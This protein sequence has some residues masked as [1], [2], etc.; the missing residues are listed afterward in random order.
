MRKT[1]VIGITLLLLLAVSAGCSNSAISETQADNPS[2][3]AD[4]HSPDTYFP[5]ITIKD[6]NNDIEG[7][8]HPGIET[9][10]N[11]HPN[12]QYTT[13]YTTPDKI[14]NTEPD[15]PDTLQGI[16]VN[17]E[18]NIPDFSLIE[19]GN[20][21]P[22]TLIAAYK[23]FCELINSLI[24]DYG[25]GYNTE[26]E[27]GWAPSYSGVVYAELIDFNNDGLPELFVVFNNGEARYD[28]IWAVYGYT[29]NVESYCK[30]YIGGEGGSG[31]NAEIALSGNGSRYLVYT[32]GYYVYGE[33]LD[34]SYYTVKND[35]WDTALTR[36]A[37]IPD[38]NKQGISDDFQWQ[39]M[40]N[41]FT[42][43]ENEYEKA[44]ETELGIIS[45]RTIPSFSRYDED[46]KLKNKRAS[47]FMYSFLT[48]LED[49]IAQLETLVEPSAMGT[50]DAGTLNTAEAIFGSIYC[51]T[52]N[53]A[54]SFDQ[55][56]CQACEV[57]RYVCNIAILDIS[58][59]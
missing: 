53:S 8:E 57:E 18:S 54:S 56:L 20:A 45:T 11:K 12:T 28:D 5:Q 47:D 55:N 26:G 16:T 50:T 43:S 41:G 21:A 3:N 25:I 42:V 52:S 4:T 36:S 6:T 59:L 33:E 40:V 30:L 46:G 17:T 24:D 1:L 7:S 15:T 37:S 19:N 13:P 58:S 27:S 9:D 35:S 38:K 23:A 14:D 32:Y 49:R 10:K 51:N 22:D 29:G 48:A 39:W 2:I 34:F 44:P 31:S